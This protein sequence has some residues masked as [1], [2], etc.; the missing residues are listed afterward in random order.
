VPVE[1]RARVAGSG[2]SANSAYGLAALATGL[3]RLLTE[4]RLAARLDW[5]LPVLERTLFSAS[6]SSDAAAACRV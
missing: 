4:L 1:K 2:R 3:P 6:A 5:V